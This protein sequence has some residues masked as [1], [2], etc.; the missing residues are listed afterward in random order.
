MKKYDK[1]QNL[2]GTG[3]ELVR[4][5]GRVSVRVRVRVRVRVS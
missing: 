3:N 5:R 4:G 1:R 2:R